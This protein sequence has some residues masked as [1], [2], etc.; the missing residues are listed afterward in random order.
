MANAHRQLPFA[1]IGEL[2]SGVTGGMLW[3]SLVFIRQCSIFFRFREYS[4]GGFSVPGAISLV[5]SI[6]NA[7]GLL[8]KKIRVVVKDCRVIFFNQLSI[9][10]VLANLVQKGIEFPKQ[11]GVVRAKSDRHFLLR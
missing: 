8:R 2:P 9:P 6:Q 5:C 7:M 10:S 3:G 1:A 4:P 11:T